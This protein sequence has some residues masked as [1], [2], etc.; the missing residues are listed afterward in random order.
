MAV[1]QVSFDSPCRLRPE[2]NSACVMMGG[3]SDRVAGLCTFTFA[4]VRYS[5][6]CL[7]DSQ[8]LDGGGLALDGGGLALVDGG[9][10]LDGGGLGLDGGGLLTD[11]EAQPLEIGL[12]KTHHLSIS[13]RPHQAEG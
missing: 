9:F 4:C 3:G 13:I 8:C 12:M 11:E 7:L 10:G 6:V 1:A 2:W 5:A